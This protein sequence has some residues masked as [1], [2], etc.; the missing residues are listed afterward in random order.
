MSAELIILNMVL[1]KPGAYLREIQEKLGHVYAVDMHE[2]T[3]C[4]FLK[5]SG[6]TRQKMKMVAARL[7]RN[8]R[9]M[10]T[11]DVRLY[12]P[13]ML[14]FVD[15]TG[16]DMR[17]NLRKYG[18]SARGKPIV[19]HKLPLHGQ[20][21]SAI[22]AMTSTGILD[23]KLSQDTVDSDEFK[24]F[25]EGLQLMLMN[26]NG[27]NPNSIVILDNC[28]IHHANDIAQLLREV[29]V[30]VYFLPPYSP[31]YNPIEEAFSK[32]KMVLKCMEY[33]A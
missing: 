18:Y 10:F 5:K 8:L 24:D 29:G 25:I 33:I 13:S 7:D 19:S 22:V 23:Y 26:F 1:Q 30:M 27:R 31:D 14:V 15:E 11:V 32:V 28:A 16:T 4:K 17:D 20:R 3:L 21:V 2:S 12:D 6:F 9:E